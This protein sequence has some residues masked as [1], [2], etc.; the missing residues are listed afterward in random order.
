LRIGVISDTHLRGVPQGFLQG[1]KK[2]FHGVELV[3]HCGDWVSRGVLDAMVGQGWEVVGVAGNMDPSEIHCVVPV[4][5]EL[6]LEGIK[7]GLVHGWGAPGGIE[8]RVSSAFQRVELVVFGHTHRPFWGRW[9][10]LWLFNPGAASGW[11]NPQGPTV[12]ILEVGETLRASIV[13]LKGEAG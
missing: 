9:G 4:K 10:E 13:P 6:E 5:R 1:L 12:G 11:G 2:A 3:L 7:I 8:A